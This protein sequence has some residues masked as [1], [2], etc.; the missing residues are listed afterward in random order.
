MWQACPVADRLM[1]LDTPTLYYRAF[2][3][4][5]ESIKAPDGMPV[6][7]VRGT[8]DF[9]S[10]LVAGFG[11]NRLVA[12]FDADWRPAFRVA[13]IPS[14]KTHRLVGAADAIGD[15]GKS[16]EPAAAGVVEE[17]VPDTLAPQVPVLEA[18]LDAFGLARGWADGF[19]ADDAIAAYCAAH[20]S[21]HAGPVDVVTGDRDMFQL[22]DDASGVRVLNIARGVS[23]LE[24][25]DDA[26][27]AAKYALPGG[28]AYAGFAT[29]R[30]DP[31]DGLPG[32]AGVGDK[33]AAALITEFGSLDGLLAAVDDPESVL[34]PAVRKKLDAA[35]D[36]L[37]VAPQVVNVRADAP[38]TSVESALPSEPADAD[39]LDRL[40]QQ[41][42]LG[43]PIKR[44]IKAL[45]AAAAVPDES[46]SE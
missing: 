12:C 28:R 22:V 30:G 3:G 19:E 41:Y 37:A 31:S 46:E 7:A 39:E 10:A 16:G 1:L 35:R 24:V 29:L 5:P 6:N 26:T 34:K 20:L 33:T 36:Y 32:V 43:S 4:I 23:K 25:M 11:P 18:V 17:E 38:V 44:L 15:A 45:A 42:N 14:Y 13:A 21:K 40:G 27:I 8:L 2:Y 9:I